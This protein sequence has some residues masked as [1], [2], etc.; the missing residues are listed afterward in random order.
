MADAPEESSP[1]PDE[2]RS[3]ASDLTSLFDR[4]GLIGMATWD[5][6]LPQGPLLPSLL[7]W[8]ARLP[9]PPRGSTLIL[10][11]HYPLT[12]DD[13]LLTVILE[14]QRFLAE[15]LELD[16]SV[17]GLPHYKIYARLLEVLHHDRA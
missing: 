15:R 11:V 5:L 13:D 9:Y 16:A 12:G 8:A 2:V 10:P 1:A 3:F 7:A 4:W 14:Q 6:P 17:A